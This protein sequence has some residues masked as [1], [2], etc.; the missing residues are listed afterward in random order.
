MDNKT[1]VGIKMVKVVDTDP[2]ISYLGRYERS[3]EP[4][5]IDRT[6]FDPTYGSGNLRYFVPANHW[7]HNPRSW[8]LVLEEVKSRVLEKYR[9]LKRADWCYAV[10][11][12]VRLGKLGDDWQF[13]GIYAS[14]QIIVGDVFQ[15][16]KSAGLWGIE[17]DSSDE[18]F[19]EV[20]LEEVA[21]L[22]DI[23]RDLGF[24]DSEIDAVKVVQ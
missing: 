5:A 24:P 1:I 17:S 20:A 7:P 9:T 12:M 13:V 21:S 22:K 3:W 4:G 23:L 11:D 2:D 18:Y 6:R 16:I 8:D 19:R 14:A 10:Q 15:H